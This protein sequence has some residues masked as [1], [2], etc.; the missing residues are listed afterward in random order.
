MKLIFFGASHGIPEPNRK[1]SSTLIEVE[2]NRYF[3][4]MGSQAIEQLINRGIPI[5]SVK[6][7]FVTH[8]HGDHTNGLIS[9]LDLCSWRFCEANPVICLPGNIESTKRALTDWLACNGTTLRPFEFCHTTEGVVFDD[10]VLRVTAYRTRHI[11]F[12]YSYLVEAQGKRVL[13]SGDL[14]H[15]PADDFPI[16][17]LSSPLDLAI[18]ESAHFEATE[19]LPILE[20]NANL[21]RLCFNHYSSR[22]LASVMQ[23]KEIFSKTIDVTLA[24]D[25]LE[26]V[27]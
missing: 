19:Y 21:K 23:A 13:F 15:T 16:A 26:I 24:T 7:V 10:G 8:M 3:I 2:G 22:H 6:A 12:S 20:G 1:C 27:I 25:G 18:C 4:D 14:S 17:V 11:D 5:E 9:F